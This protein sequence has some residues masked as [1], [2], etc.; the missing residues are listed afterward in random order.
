ME[1]GMKDKIQ[2]TKYN[3]GSSKPTYHYLRVKVKT[4]NENYFDKYFPHSIDYCGKDKMIFGWNFGWKCEEDHTDVP[5][6]QLENAKSLAQKLIKHK[7]IVKCEIINW[8]L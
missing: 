5:A 8:F 1:E 2:I 6:K 7:K 4:T 3:W